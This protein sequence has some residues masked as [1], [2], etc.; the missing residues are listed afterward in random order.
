M[1]ASPKWKVYCGTEYRGCMKYAEDAAALCDLFG[2]E[3]TI[4]RGH[5]KRD[6]V[7]DNAVDGDAGDSYDE[8]ASVC[9]ERSGAAY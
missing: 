4:R 3:G 7:W 2:P 9:R 5:A 1:A 6:I 8:T